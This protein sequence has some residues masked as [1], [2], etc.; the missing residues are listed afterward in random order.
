ML[1]LGMVKYRDLEAEKAYPGKY[2]VA[3]YGI[4]SGFDRGNSFGRRLLPGPS[5]TGGADPDRTVLGRE[6]QDELDTVRVEVDRLM[7]ELRNPPDALRDAGQRLTRLYAVYREQ[8]QLVRRRLGSP[9]DYDG[10]LRKAEHDFSRTLAELKSGLP[11]LL[12][13]EVKTAGIKYNLKF[14][15]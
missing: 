9:A 7:E 11:G 15:E 8:D 1:S 13:E 12:R 5:L 10:L 14:M 3:L 6:E 2:V 4:E